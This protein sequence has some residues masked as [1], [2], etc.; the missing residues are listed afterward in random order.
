MATIAACLATAATL[1]EVS[2]SARLDVEV[3]LAHVLEQNRT[4]LYTW[5]EKSLSP[6]QQ[7]Q[8]DALLTRRRAGEPVAHLTG[9][10]EFWSLTLKVNDSTLIPRPDTELLVEQVLALAPARQ[11][12]KRLVDLG[13]GTG[14]I[15]LAVASERPEWE[16]LA[17]DKSPD[18]VALAE[19]NRKACGFDHVS[20]RESDWF[21]AAGDQLFDLIVSNP[22]YIDAADPHLARGDV[23]FEPASALVAGEAGLADIQLIAAQGYSRLAEQGWLLLEHGCDQGAQVRDI[24][25]QAGFEQVRTCLDLAQLERV[26]LGCRAGGAGVGG[27]SIGG[28]TASEVPRS[29]YLKVTGRF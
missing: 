4:H 7:T 5:P 29:G 20:V 9:V 14:A 13:T 23:R 16:I 10:R 15:A 24:L 11:G 25:H 1:A 19:H 8:F 27:G 26:S 18:A 12:Q 3:L 21:A 17:L 28:A 6:A 2:D 22:P